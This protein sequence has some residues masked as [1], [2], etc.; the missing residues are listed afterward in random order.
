MPLLRRILVH[1]R[2]HTAETFL[3]LRPP[4]CIPEA[5][6]VRRSILKLVKGPLRQGWALR[7]ADP[8]P[9]DCLI[10]ELNP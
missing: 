1:A 3:A 9:I 7:S 2:H 8:K 10:H 5:V 6:G 4:V